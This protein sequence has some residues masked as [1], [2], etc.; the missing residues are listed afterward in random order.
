[1]ND[2]GETM[3]Y[4]ASQNSRW[5]R[6]VAMIFCAFVA[7]SGIPA[8]G[9]AAPTLD[10]LMADFGFGKDDVQR[11]RDG[12]MVKTTTKETSD[13]EIATV[14]AFL[15]KA[16]V[17]KIISAFEAGMF[18]HYDPQVQASV[19][20][21]GDGTLDDF[22]S[23]VL[24]PGGGKE[25]QRYLDAA[26]GSTLNL[27]NSEIA[28]FQA[29]RES[30]TAAQ[31]QVEQALRQ[32]LLARY[33]AYRLQGLAGIAPY[34]RGE[35]EQTQP[36]DSLRSATEAAQP[37]RKYV[38]SFYAVLTKYPAERPPGFIERFFWI[39]YA[40]DG[41]PN[42]TLRHRMALPV[43]QGYVVADR[44][45]YVGFD[46]NETQAIAGFLPIAE[47]TAAVYVDRTTTDQLGG[48]GASA[49]QA[50][51]RSL[52]AKEFGEIL[53]KVRVEIKDR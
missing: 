19:E 27:S 51:G 20:I 38:P 34:A 17:K 26:P 53:Q 10:E 4:S 30:G 21:R 45:Y 42:F 25:T 1:M 28:A 7:F 29:L 33:Q 2:W 46:Y 6:S 12:E 15:A 47:G 3:L 31:P 22:K 43:D 5:V 48:F 36:A 23:L 8:P 39:R 52:L 32:M 24:Q 44:E 41:R 11:V 9:L 14:M 50:I 37:L 35:D 13:R 18:F 49:K 16:P 40:M